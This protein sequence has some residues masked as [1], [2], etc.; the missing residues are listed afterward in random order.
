VNVAYIVTR[1][2]PMGGVQVHVRDLAAAIGAHGHHPTVII[3]GNGPLL[4]QLEERGI[5]T[6][7]AK[8]LAMPINPMRDLQALREI[9]RL[10]KELQ[11]DL[12]AVHS[13]KAGILGRLAARSLRIPVILTA[14]GWTFTPG[15]PRLEAA[16]YRRIERLA[17]RFTDK[18][19]TVSEFDRQLG[20]SARI[21]PDHRLVTVYN[22]IPDVA[23]HLRADPSRTPVRLI[24]VARLAPQKDHIT[25]LRAL[26]GLR[27]FKWELDLVGEGPLLDQTRALADSLQ[28][29]SRVHFLG[30]R[31][32]VEQLLAGAQVGILISNWEGFP[33]S[34]LEAMRAGLPV[35]ASAIAGVGESVRDDETGYLVPR[36]DVAVLRDRLARVLGDPLLR[37]R[38]G[39]GGRRMYERHFTLEAMVQGV[40]AVYHEVVGASKAESGRHARIPEL[41][42]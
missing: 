10:L 9:S 28:L 8:H 36:G 6:I 19:M 24:M 26:A 5:R 17:G 12:V 38:L 2:D 11:P 31:T 18:I 33:I 40:L 13:A 20:L 35:V 41:R 25:L 37:A 16:V 21:V 23:A 3:G 1:A 22:G 34:I 29:S 39:S 42:A 4:A 32:D 30:Q 15:I 27:D 14:H 7:V